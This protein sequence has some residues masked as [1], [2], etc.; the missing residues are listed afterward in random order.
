MTDIGRWNERGLAHT[1]YI[2][3][4]DPLGI[5]SIGFISFYGFCVLRMRKCNTKI[6]FLENVKDRD[7]VLAS[8]LHADIGTVIFCK[9]ITQFLQSSGEGRKTSLFIFRTIIGIGNTDSG[10]DLCFMDIKST[11]IFLDDFEQ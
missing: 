2:K 1:A 10:K 8:R 11:A 5:F 4:T 9:L 6:I 3:V 7:P